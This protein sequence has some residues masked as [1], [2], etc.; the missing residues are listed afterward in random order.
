MASI[1]T[2]ANAFLAKE[3]MTPK[4]LQKL[5][6]YFVAWGWALFHKNMADDT[7]FEAWVHGPVSEE[8]RQKYKNYGWECITAREH[9]SLSPEEQDLLDSV[10]L[11]YGALSGN[12]LEALTHT[13]R[14]WIN[15]RENLSS[16][17][18]SRNKI[19]PSDMEKYYSSIYIGD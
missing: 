11:T 10:W 12:E 15:A 16:Y 17:E 3:S 1:Y 9:Y 5:S 2:V 7:A 4:K 8:L 6:Y 13:E 18:R 14:P 19:S